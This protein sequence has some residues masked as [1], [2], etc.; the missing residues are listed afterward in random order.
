MR[1]AKAAV[2]FVVVVLSLTAPGTPAAQA[3]F[4]GTNGKIAFGDV[5]QFGFGPFR[6]FVVGPDGNGAAALTTE[7]GQHPAWSPDG[8]QLAYDCG[9]L[10]LINE[11]GSGVIPVP[12]TGPP[13]HP[14]WSPDGKRLTFG[15]YTEVA[16]AIGGSYDIY[17]INLDGSGETRVTTNDQTEEMLP[18]WSPDGSR[19]A[20][21][22][23]YCPEGQCNV[24]SGSDVYSIRPDGTGGTALTTDGL[25]SG[26]ALAD[27]IHNS[28]PDWSPDG[29]ELVFESDRAGEL[30]VY[31]MTADGSA[32]TNLTPDPADQPPE[33]RMFG[34][35]PAWSPDGAKIAFR[36]ARNGSGVYVM[37]SNGAD[38]HLVHAAGL[39]VVDWQPRCDT[40]GC[41]KPPDP[42]APPSP[43]GVPAGNS[44]GGSVLGLRDTIPPV[45]AIAT[46]SSQAALKQGGVVIAASCPT[47]ACTVRASGSISVPGAAARTYALRRTSAKLAKG[48]RAKLKL[49]FGRAAKKAVGRAFI[50][51]RTLRATIRLEASDD[52]G[53]RSFARKTLRLRK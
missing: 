32:Q 11:D 30:D 39:E 51:R 25:P 13:S 4:P 34:A 46:R 3:A 6:I 20:Y 41:A 47:E 8:K 2:W 5:G 12:T 50:R 17:V 33:Q 16:G 37:S 18:V 19:I 14:A 15:A 43:P 27:L 36:G 38:P 9:G 40:G 52:A 44:G 1:L 22:V 48:S 26:P 42:P 49:R 45:M 35:E 10:C 7:F 24:T 29:S 21:E 23:Q 28:F 53:N 31:K